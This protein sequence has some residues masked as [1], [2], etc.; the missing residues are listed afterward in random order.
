MHPSTLNPRSG[1]NPSGRRAFGTYIKNGKGNKKG[2][3]SSAYFWLPTVTQRP[4]GRRAFGTYIKKRKG[5]K[6]GTRMSAFFV[7][8][9]G[10]EPRQAEPESDVL[11]LHHRAKKY[12][13]SAPYSFI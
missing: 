10:F 8:P 5:N 11:P 13:A 9:L 3:H 1:L 7:A 6:K 12:G 2:T 4:S